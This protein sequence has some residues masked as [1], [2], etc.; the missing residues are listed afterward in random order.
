ME[1]SVHGEVGGRSE[2][3]PG[4]PLG[5]TGRKDDEGHQPLGQMDARET[6]PDDLGGGQ[7]SRGWL[8]RRVPRLEL[9]AAED[10]GAGSWAGQVRGDWTGEPTDGA[11][12]MAIG[13]ASRAEEEVLG[14]A[15]ATPPALPDFIKEQ[16]RGDEQPLQ[17]RFGSGYARWQEDRARHRAPGKG[18]GVGGTAG[19][20]E[21]RRL[22][23]TFTM[24]CLKPGCEALVNRARARQLAHQAGQATYLPGVGCAGPGCAAKFRKARFAEAQ[25]RVAAELLEGRRWLVCWPVGPDDTSA[26]KRPADAVQRAVERALAAVAALQEEARAT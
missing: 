10:A 4:G 8:S 12:A 16:L 13:G 25:R 22:C 14:G 6:A 7:S 26:W 21:S 23:R 15:E 1:A 24:V 20:R 3:R 5:S 11:G 17:L 18:R 9:A 2:L 19:S